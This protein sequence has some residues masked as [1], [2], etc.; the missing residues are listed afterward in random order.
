MDITLIGVPI[1]YGCDRDG[2][3]YGPN[4]LR[5]VGIVS[6]IMQNGKNLYDFGNLDIPYVPISDKFASHKRIKYLDSI[7]NMNDNLAHLVYSSLMAKSFPFVI[8]GDHSLGLGSISGASRYF[9]NLA[10]IWI[11]AHG[12]I[13]TYETSPSGNSHG[14]PLAAAMG[15]GVDPMVNVYYKGAKVKPE[16]VYIIGA[17]DLDNGELLLAEKLNINLY[18]MDQVNEMG[19]DNIVNKIINKINNSNIDGVHLSYDIDVFDKSIVPG[20]GTPV[21]DGFD[22]NQGKD[23]LK[24]LLNTG[25]ITSMDLVEFNP[26]LDENNITADLCIEIIDWVFKN[27]R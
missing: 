4:K 16:N 20:T 22:L 24:E 1:M 7:V 25:L 3:Q 5:E 21:K 17:R 26:F 27:I 18:T 10:V 2:V 23:I 13:N 6:T 11:D 15:V 8:G 19:I 9:E 12:D 14:M